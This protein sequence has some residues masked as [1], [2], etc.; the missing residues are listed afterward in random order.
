MILFG[1]IQ[2]HNLHKFLLSQSV[3]TGLLAQA[4]GQLL[5]AVNSK[6][7]KMGSVTFAWYKLDC[8]NNDG[9][10]AIIDVLKAASQAST[11][12]SSTSAIRSASSS[13]VVPYF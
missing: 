8:S 10:E 11:S 9:S 12:T 6:E 4:A 7:E 5:N 2:S 3:M 13:G 1:G